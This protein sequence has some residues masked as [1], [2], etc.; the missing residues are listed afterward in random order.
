MATKKLRRQ[1]KAWIKEHTRSGSKCAECSVAFA[2]DRG[3]RKRLAI[4]PNGHG[5]SMF[6]LCFDCGQRYERGGP[7][8]MPNILK[9]AQIAVFMS[10]VATPVSSSFVH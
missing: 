9:E 3:D 1:V 2:V 4:F 7:R 6:V 10:P 5:V 8:A